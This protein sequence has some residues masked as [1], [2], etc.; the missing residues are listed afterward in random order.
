MALNFLKRKKTARPGILLYQNPGRRVQTM[1][2]GEAVAAHIE[3]SS[4][5]PIGDGRGSN[6][7]SRDEELLNE[8][9]A[10]ETN[11]D[12]AKERIEKLLIEISDILK[13]DNH[14]NIQK[15]DCS[16]LPL[17]I[18][19]LQE[20]AALARRLKEHSKIKNQSLPGEH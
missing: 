17:D 12:Q 1:R 20:V 9:N 19:E 10:E 14:D 11:W 18:Q 6:T 5:S 2:M 3:S 8:E 13:S 15:Q 7:I 4:Q 16:K